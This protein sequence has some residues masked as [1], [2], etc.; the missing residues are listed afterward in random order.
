MGMVTI[1]LNK[2]AVLVCGRKIFV[3]RA[4]KLFHPSIASKMK[5][6]R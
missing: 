4:T 5:T 2:N 3:L 1:L 6:C